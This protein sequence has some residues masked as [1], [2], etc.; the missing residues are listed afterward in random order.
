MKKDKGDEDSSV[1]W[2]YNGKEEEWDSFDRRMTRFM[3]KKLD[4]FG[5]KLWLGEIPE[6]KT[7]DKKMF[8]DHVL[9]VYQAIRI[10][11]PR[12]A[13]ELIK[14]DSEFFKKSWHLQWLARQANL[15]VDQIEDHAKGQAEVEVVNYSGDKK[16]IRMH[17]YKQ[18][19]AGSGGDIHSQELEYEKGMPDGNGLA[20]KPGMDITV[21]LRQLEGRKI[22]FWKMCEPA[23]RLKYVFCQE[24]KLV[25]IVLEHINDDYKACVDRLLDY[26][27][28]KK[29]IDA[30]KTKGPKKEVDL[31]STL[32]RSFNDDWLPSW[33][34]LQACLIEEYRNFMKEGKFPS[35]KSAKGLDKI[36]VAFGALE[37]IV[38]YA[39]GQKAHKAGDPNCKAGPYEVASIAPKEFR[40]RREAKK[41]KSE[42]GAQ[43][44]NDKKNKATGGK[45]P[46]FDFAK[47]I[48]KRGAACR[49]EHEKAAG[50]KGKGKMFNPKQKKAIKIM[51]AAA[52]KKNLSDLAKKGRAKKDK[53]KSSDDESDFAAA[54][55]PFFLAPCTN[56]IP[57]H[58]M[59]SKN[60]VMSTNLHDVDNSC[61]IDSDA[62]LSIST[63]ESDFAWLDK[64][65]E[66]VDSLGAP[67][68]ISGGSSEIGGIGPMVIRALSGE[69][70][71]DPNGV[72]LKS[73]KGQPNFR[74][75][76]TQRLKSLGVRCVGCFNDTDDDVLQDRV[77]GRTIKLTEEGQA[78]KSILV[79]STQK[80]PKVPI[81]NVFR[82]IVA[83]IAKG[84][85]TSLVTSLSDDKSPDA[86]Q[87]SS[88][89]V[90]KAQRKVRHDGNKVLLFNVAKCSVE[91]R[92]RL[93][94]RRFGYCDSNLLTRMCKDPDFGE[95]PNLCV[96]NEDNPVKDA[97]KFRKL[98]H[99]RT[100]PAI[101][102]RFPCWGRTY[103]DGYGGGQSMGE[104]SYDGAIGGYLFKCPT[105][106]DAHHKLYASHEQFP[107]AVFQF[108]THVEGEGHRC[109]ELYV[110]TF[111]VNISAELEEVVA[112]FQCK[113]V[114]ISVGTPQELAFVE[115]AHRVIAG[116]SR[117]MLAGAPHLPG[118][119]WALS[120]KHAVYV[121]RYLPQSSRN[122]KSAHF[123]NTGRV[124]DWRNLSIHVFG[125]PCRFAELSGPVHKRSEVTI[126]G[127][128]VG[129]QH[130]MILI[131]RKSDMKLLS[132]SR[133]KCV[134]YE[135]AYICPLANSPDDL[136]RATEKHVDDEDEPAIKKRKQGRQ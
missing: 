91:E 108:L 123:L 130:P 131:L 16:M 105:T 27:K 82:Q 90:N 103:V 100:D 13:K 111:A 112:M 40:D 64:S 99:H 47:G 136:R 94:V 134:V 125:A 72:Y 1:G 81:T 88:K 129:V 56:K 42:G 124:P 59:K 96:L 83:D 71:I 135:S 54:L 84:N 66:S 6:L 31:P 70:L 26:V 19:G 35:G 69:Y 86:D 80:V 5:E 110:D 57:R 28:V 48:C 12:E 4:L 95:L 67:S 15:M 20:F 65:P 101:S 30:T 115:T 62:G 3:R 41:R 52:V 8:G 22:Y 93:Y 132:C 7:M 74:V 79:L 87:S 50:E 128:F 18:F 104:E 120:D 14:K 36:P 55:A 34:N 107:A 37:D 58:P 49:F 24:P 60:I 33:A 97:S 68:G 53:D 29:L 116:R 46:C 106:G 21:K 127:F 63:L 122:W 73:S 61:G 11:L 117:A 114:P 2:T 51:L 77:S 98:T 92:S 17:L 75:L 32:D 44:G 76:A 133:K 121:G 102:Q 38:C 89:P 10:T 23:K 85:R 126:E 113:V 118:W 78:N 119:C 39:C 43:Q 109:Y 25:R 45:K 9:A